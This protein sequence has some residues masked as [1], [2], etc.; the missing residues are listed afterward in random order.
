MHVAPYRHNRYGYLPMLKIATLAH[1]SFI[2]ELIIDG[3]RS[4]AFVSNLASGEDETGFFAGLQRG[5]VSKHINVNGE[6]AILHAYVYFNPAKNS[7]RS[8][9]PAL[10]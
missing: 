2:R 4:G 10:A 8:I 5:L 9:N 1:F 7:K 6:Q 3:A